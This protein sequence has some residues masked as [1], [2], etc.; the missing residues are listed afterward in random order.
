MV[1]TGRSAERAE[2]IAGAIGGKTTGLA[3]DL[4]SPSEIA[5]RLASVGAV[6]HL[7][8]AA[9]ERDQNQVREF[10]LEGALRLVTLKLVGNAEV[11]HT[12][13]PRLA[14]S[15]SILL[16]EAGQGPPYPARRPSAPST[17]V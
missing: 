4:A 7:V 16:F 11:I 12:L 1:I 9:I 15:A 14:D 2:E 10:D 3:L 8:L 6:Q 13:V 5:E 17:A